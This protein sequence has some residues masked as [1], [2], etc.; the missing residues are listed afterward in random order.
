MADE[1]PPPPPAGP[2]S[3]GNADEGVA[4]RNAVWQ[5]LTMLARVLL[6]V[7]RILIS[8]LFGQTLYGSYRIASDLWETV[9][10]TSM[11]ASDK[12]LLRFIAEDRITHRADLER[13]TLGTAFRLVAGASLAAGIALALGAPWLAGIWKDA[14]ATPLLRAM[15]ASVV[16]CALAYT[17]VAAA[18]GRKA[19]RVNLFVRGLAEPGLLLGAVIAAGLVG[20]GVVSLGLAHA[21]TYLALLLLS[22]IGCAAVFGGGR[23][24]DSLRAPRRA[25]FYAFVLPLAAAELMN[26]LLMRVGVFLLGGFR[27]PDVVALLGAAEELGRPIAAA[28][29]VFDPIV[30]TAVAE[31][32]KLRDM[33]RLTHNVRFLTR[34]VASAAAPIAVVV[35]ALRGDLL[36]LYG[37][38]FPQAGGVL[39]VLGLGHM[40]NAVGG[41]A[42]GLLPMSGRP[43]AF[44]FN[45]LGAAIANVVLCLVLI[46]RYGLMGAAVASTTATALLIG[47]LIVQT[48]TQVKVHP[49][50]LGLLKPAAAAI[51][52]AL[53]ALGVR[54]LPLPLVARIAAVALAAGLTYAIALLLLRPEERERRLVLSLLMPWKRRA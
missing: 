42:A 5:T 35:F 36:R 19:M 39:I 2:T 9:S 50:H 12:G 54:A 41:I 49:F 17:L 29:Y 15:G 21:S 24:L 8:R 34:W 26:L 51:P 6:P 4:A 10:R 22:A 37:P 45:N 38:A 47:A 23:L 32:F 18:L 25:G 53:A 46:P 14:A 44:F 28:R 27:G 7:H 48:A 13:S 31:A 1:A 11:V 40:C 33:E 20:G 43:L 30:A 3:H 52:S 16:F